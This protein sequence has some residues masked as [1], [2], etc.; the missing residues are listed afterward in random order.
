MLTTIATRI[1][2]AVPKIAQKKL[3]ESELSIDSI[4]ISETQPDKYRMSVNSTIRTDGK[5]HAEIDGFEGA[6]YLEDLE[7]HAPFAYID[8]PPTSSAKVSTVNISQMIDIRD[9]TEFTRFNTWLLANETLR[10]TV[11]GD[12]KVHVKGLSKAYGVTFKKTVELKGLNGFHG[13][14]VTHSDIAPLRATN[15]HNAT[16]D[17]PNPSILTIH[18]VRPPSLLPFLCWGSSG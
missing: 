18:I 9:M 12:T 17:I 4:V 10:M 3:D 11:E 8:F 14:K 6:M 7:G 13:L 1:F 5:V 2:V 16:V 15:N